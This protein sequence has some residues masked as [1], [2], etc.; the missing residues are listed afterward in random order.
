MAELDQRDPR[1]DPT[2]IL[3]HPHLPACAD[4]VG[5]HGAAD[6]RCDVGCHEWRLHPHG[7]RQGSD[8]LANRLEARPA[9]RADFDPDLLTAHLRGIARGLLYYRSDLWFSRFRARI[10]GCDWG[11][12]LLKDHGHHVSLRLWD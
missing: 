6:T 5:K 1:L 11:S 4:S 8:A 12:G 10:L 9:Q 2:E 7:A 3:G